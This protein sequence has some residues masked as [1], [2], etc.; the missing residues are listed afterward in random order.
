MLLT[1]KSCALLYLVNQILKLYNKNREKEE[2]LFPKSEPL[3]PH[4][5]TYPNFIECL[6]EHCKQKGE[7]LH[8]LRCSPETKNVAVWDNLMFLP[9]EENITYPCISNITYID[10]RGIR[11]N[12]S[13]TG[14][15]TYKNIYRLRL[16][17]ANFGTFIYQYA[18]ELLDSARIL[19]VTT[20]EN[21]SVLNYT[22]NLHRGTLEVRFPKYIFWIESTRNKS[23]FSLAT[24]CLTTEDS[25]KLGGSKIERCFSDF[26]DF[27]RTNPDEIN[28][29]RLLSGDKINWNG[30]FNFHL[31]MAAIIILIVI[32]LVIKFY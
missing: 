17:N 2:L 22:L 12:T 8:F 21:P 28:K 29:Q 25:L 5:K 20:F 16:E 23:N 7:N 14:K 24:N 10:L 15:L 32:G 3:S 27:N 31:P 11:F 19:D 1:R 13:K 30:I 9:D 18:S 26:Y 4:N 6:T